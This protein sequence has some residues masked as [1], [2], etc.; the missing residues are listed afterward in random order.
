MKKIYNRYVHAKENYHR[1]PPYMELGSE[2]WGDDF[3]MT[4]PGD[5]L[6][7]FQPG[8]VC[9]MTL[10]LSN[11][12][13]HALTPY[14]YHDPIPANATDLASYC[15]CSIAAAAWRLKQGYSA[16]FLPPLVWEFYGTADDLK[17]RWDMGSMWLYDQ[18]IRKA[19]SE[20]VQ[21]AKKGGWMKEYVSVQA[22][23]AHE[24][25]ENLRKDEDDDLY[26]D[27][28][29]GWSMNDFEL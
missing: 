5:D 29:E 21:R 16:E 17:R 7:H 9:T 2:R 11:Q 22:R 24:W 6:P 1:R 18:Y 25:S 19:T 3:N 15:P 4:I 28:Y 13:S 20:E 10:A 23:R 14:P 27:E 8:C 12:L 26:T